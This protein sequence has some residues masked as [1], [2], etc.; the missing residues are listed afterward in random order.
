MVRKQVMIN[1]SNAEGNEAMKNIEKYDK[2]NSMAKEDPE[3]AKNFVASS[4]A[5]NTEK[6]PPMFAD[7]GGKIKTKDSRQKNSQA[8]SEVDMYILEC[9]RRDRIALGCYLRNMDKD[10]LILCYS[11]IGPEDFRPLALSLGRNRTITVL[12]IS[13]NWLGDE[14]SANW[15]FGTLYLCLYIS[16]RLL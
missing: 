16:F 8:P 3:R 5:P 13:H 12:N 2:V 1:V 10:K 14:V 7:T 11:N 15:L 4:Q 9:T 6:V